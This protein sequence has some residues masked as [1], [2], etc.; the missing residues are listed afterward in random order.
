MD[1][2]V[3][4]R[5]LTYVDVGRRKSTY[6]GPR[7]PSSGMLFWPTCVLYTSWSEV[8]QW[9]WFQNCNFILCPCPVCGSAGLIKTI[10][11]S[12]FARVG[13]ALSCLLC[14]FCCCGDEVPHSS[15][16]YY[17]GSLSPWVLFPYTNVT[18]WTRAGLAADPS[19]H[20][21]HEVVYQSGT[22]C[23]LERDSLRTLDHI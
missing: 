10:V 9:I 22:Q 15:S 19:P 1:V 16:A 5:T 8:C 11:W 4:R 13:F 23:G 21:E 14:F 18:M 6:S 20:L 3:R 12:M 7:K 2:D 17:F